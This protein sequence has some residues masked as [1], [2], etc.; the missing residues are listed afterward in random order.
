M[1]FRKNLSYNLVVQAIGPVLSFLSLFLIA[2]YG[3]AAIQGRFASISSWINLAIVI[4]VFGFPQSFVYLIN[5]LSISSKVLTSFS[6]HYSLIFLSSFVIISYSL[7]KLNIVSDIV[8]SSSTQ[9]IYLSISI[10]ILVFHGLL[11]GIYLTYNQSILFASFSILPAAF[12]FIFIL[13]GLILGNYNFHLIFLFSSVLVLLGVLILLKPI[14]NGFEKP[15]Q[16]QIPWKALF[17]HGTNTFFQAL[18]L[19]LQPVI[20][21]W[22]I[23]KYIGSESEIGY[24]NLGLFLVQGFLVPIGMVSPLLFEHWTKNQDQNFIL[25]YTNIPIFLFEIL[26]GGIISIAIYYLIPFIFGSGYIPSIQIAQILLIITP[27]IFHIRILI[28]AIHSKGYPHYNTYS[29]FFRLI[30]FICLS[31]LWVTN[32]DQKLVG[33]AVCWSISELFGAFLT[34]RLF[35]KLHIKDLNKSSLT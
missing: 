12:L 19:A 28:P 16:N 9:I 15:S 2:R 21:Y 7:F 25:R 8:I 31:F 10:T 1:S 11:R 34:I 5:K 3:G 27:L 26:L 18:F 14:F 29:G 35:N 13:A 33:L 6:F 24:F 30:I 23:N 20:A 17:N 32:L 4:G 22:F